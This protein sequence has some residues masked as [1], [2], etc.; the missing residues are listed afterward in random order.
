MYSQSVDRINRGCIVFLVDQSYSMTDGIAGSPRP[1]ALAVESA[2]NRLLNELMILCERGEEKPRPYFD[3]GLLGYT[4]DAEGSEA[5]FRSFCPPELAQREMA[6][7]V[8]LYDHQELTSEEDDWSPGMP[9]WYR[10][11]P[12]EEMRGTPTCAVLA[13]CREMVS[14]WCGRYPNSFPPIVLHLTDGECTDGD[15]EPLAASLRSL[16]T[17]DG[18]VLLFNCHI[19]QS[20]EPATLFPGEIESLADEYARQ[21]FR[22]S[23]ELPE[24]LRQIAKARSVPTPPN[25]RAMAFNADTTQLLLLLNVGTQVLARPQ[26]P[27]SQ[28]P[29]HL[30]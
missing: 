10:S 23:S 24:P 29:A 6:N 19:S 15:P 7:I 16:S 20:S 5:V 2:I 11:P 30:R 4:T 1:K 13:R 3:V 17:S 22:M 25:A 26:S 21:L 9:I 27:R 18:P 14:E 8:D 12:T 28:R